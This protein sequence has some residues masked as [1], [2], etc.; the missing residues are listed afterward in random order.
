MRTILLG[1]MTLI[2]AGC[3]SSGAPTSVGAP[4]RTSHFLAC[5]PYALSAGTK[6]AKAIEAAKASGATV[7]TSDVLGALDSKVASGDTAALAVA[8]GPYL[9]DLVADGNAQAKAVQA[10]LKK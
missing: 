10:K 4:E 5:L 2:L 7:Q 3:A 9:A 1:G 6:D 8:C